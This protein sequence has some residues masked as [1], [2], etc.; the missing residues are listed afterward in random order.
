MA[1]ESVKTELMKEMTDEEARSVVAGWRVVERV[2]SVAWTT[3]TVVPVTPG[4]V[5]RV[6]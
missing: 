5:G 3:T 6:A 4:T 1:R 2:E